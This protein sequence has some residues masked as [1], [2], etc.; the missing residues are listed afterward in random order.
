MADKRIADFA[1]LEEA[2]DDDLL[3][4]SSEGETYNMKFGTFK[5]AVQG[6]ADRAAAAAEAAKA[7]AQLATGV[8]DEA[9][10]A[11]EAAESKA[12]DAK[13][14]AT[15]AA[16]NAQAAAQS[17]NS[18][19]ESAA[20]SEQA[21]LDATEAVA[22][23][24]EFAKDFNSLK[25]TVKGKVDDA[26]VEDG[27]L[28]MTADDE[29]VVGPLGPFSGGGGGGG[30][31]AGS[32]IRIVN[33]LT[34]RAF[35]VM[36]GATVE[37]KFNWTSTDTSDEQPTGDGSATWRI[38]GTKVA[39]QAVSQ[40]DCAFD[41]TKYLSPASA[42]TIKLTIEDAY[43]NNK[44]FTWTVT[45]STYDLAWNLGTLAFHG[46]S[47]FTVRLTPTGEGTKT[48]HMTVDGTEVFTR[49]VATTGRS[50]TATID[51][52]ALELT[53]GAHTVEAWLEV[54]AG[55]EVDYAP[56]PCRHLDEGGQQ[57]AGY[58]S[59]SERNRN[60]AVRDRKHQLHGV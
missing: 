20:R 32:L 28:Y 18:A 25:T 49:E 22:S 29:V 17:A 38:N 48:I 24:N 6:D 54:T 27:Y 4:V 36:N 7:A 41:V 2:Q 5:E 50:V 43:G 58:R 34:S 14:K 44:S 55:G 39:T 40:G 37:I 12:Q 13:T 23:V 21:L 51:P 59:V 8:S 53:H 10:K 31:D 57:Y 16:A 45:V 9:L 26:Y 19:Q 3:L 1:T 42:N 52:T 60:P 46:S 47:V 30:G 15:Q 11:A 56:A 35:S 33:K